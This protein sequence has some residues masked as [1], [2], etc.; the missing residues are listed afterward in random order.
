MSGHAKV[1]VVIPV[2]NGE[3]FIRN[4]IESAWAQGP[5]VDEVLICDDGSTDGTRRLVE[6]LGDRV[7]LLAEPHSGN[8]SVV[9]NAGVERASCEL[10]A[11]LD[12]DDV[13][14]PGKIEAQLSALSAHP[15]IG[16]VST[17]ALRQ[18]APGRVEG[19]HPLLARAA[20]A[21]GS[22]LDR[23]VVGNFIITSSVLVRRQLLLDA[24]L[25]CERE[26]LPGIEDYDL[27]LRVACIAQVAFLERPWLV[28]RD[29]GPNYRSEWSAMETAKGLLR[30]L[31]R[32]EE[33]YPGTRSAHR[34]AFRTRR[35]GLNAE[36]AEAAMAVGD[37]ST[38]RAAAW[39]V[40]RERPQAPGTWK[41]LAR[42]YAGRDAARTS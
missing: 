9:R 20:G 24:G 13:W 33:R 5:V 36:I 10:I 35:A 17:N 16:L 14:L 27:W 6:S 18:T 11:F 21:S 23:L 22:V 40:V 12:A 31:D 41:R 3:A 29:W 30:V 25:F 15:G 7:T 32:V 4:A 42:A 34:A 2:Y 1:S 37:A 26:H 28:Y 8:P 19:L 39:R 38:A